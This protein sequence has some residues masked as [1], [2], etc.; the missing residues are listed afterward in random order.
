MIEPWIIS[1]LDLLQTHP[2]I[3]LRDPQRMIQKGAYAVDG[4][5]EQ[6]GFTVLF[7]T[8]NLG[9]RDLYERL[10]DDPNT[11]V[12][13][14]DRSRGD[15]TRPLFY[16]D[17]AASAGRTQQITLTL[18]D[19]LVE[20]TGDAKWP[21]LVD[22]RGLSRLV[23]ATLPETIEAHRALRRVDTSRFADSDLYK[24]V[25]GAALR[26]DPFKKLSTSEIRRLC[27]EQ[28]QA[29]E[30]LKGVLPADVLD[31]LQRTIQAA[32]RP[33]CWLLDRDPVLVLRAFTLAT[34]MHEHGLEYQILLSNL[35]PALHEYR[36]ID[37]AFLDQALQD[38][39][40]ADPD[41]VIADVQDAEAFLLEEPSRLAFLLHDRL[42]IEEPRQAIETLKRERLSPLMRGLALV[43]L[44][45]DLIIDK[46]VKTHRKVI[47]LL[48]K[49]TAEATLPALRR[50]G[51]SWET[52]ERT[53]RRA[54]EVFELT[55]R[56]A[57]HGKKLAVAPA[58]DLTLEEFDR[59]WNQE[60]LNRLDYYVSDL[61]RM[62]RIGAM[63]PA[64]ISAFWP[65]LAARWD[66][67]RNRLKEVADAVVEVQALINRRFQDL[68][69]LHFATWIR[70]ADA[71]VVFTHQFL[72]RMLQAHWDPLSKRKAVILVFD[73]LRTDAW[74]ELLRPVLEERY[75]VV[76]SRPGSALLPTET[77]LSRKAIAAGCLP[78]EFKS[79]SELDLLQTWLKS[80]MGLSLRFQ[81]V[82]D[83]D[84]VA[85]GMSVRY[86]SDRLDY[87]VFNFTDKNLHGNDQDLA[88][89]YNTTVREIIRQDV[90]SVLRELPGDALVFVTSDHGFA[91]VAKQP[92]AI[93]ER[94]VN[95]PDDVK[96][97][98]ARTRGKLESPDAEQTVDFDARLLGIPLSTSRVSNVHFNTVLF[99]RPTVTFKRPTGGFHP[100]R[101]T[102]GGLSLAECF[103][104]MVVMSRRQEQRL[105]LEI[106]SV[107]QVG[108]VSEGEL[109]SLEIVIKPLQVGPTDLAIT[110]SFSRED[111]PTRREVF[112][113]QAATYT[114]TWTPKLGDVS[115]EDRE[116]N[117]V[118]LPVTVILSYVRGQQTTRLSK[119]IDV[120]IKLD[121]TRLRRRLDSKLDLLMG[122][123]PSELR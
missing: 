83:D 27:I 56:L 45:A 61:E 34:L 14:V 53:Y 87:V 12:L 76:E 96:Y 59:L 63:L 54:L 5:A 28:H 58:Q 84:T 81:V 89:I 70:Q 60:G 31:T 79:A 90:R 43:A 6:N 10:R 7:C 50:P 113:G 121:P 88:F 98:N 52:L 16:P 104:P 69:R 9:L 78:A 99:P 95:S 32:P 91:P 46:D 20:V 97:R 49:Q 75:Q 111:I 73:G 2:L 8:G 110:L 105:A 92:L 65:E 3:I 17:L 51:E 93:P 64:P 107:Q 77:Q 57:T 114:V 42:R 13:L 18:R 112:T 4:W 38:Q 21:P 1:K 101:Y 11:H 74:D 94:L 29:I 66:A 85:S 33:F 117:A 67:A 82:K 55:A 102:H 120:R 35:D 71:P 30:D 108:S 39:L 26:I 72:P 115:D 48:D 19:Y 116:R 40:A 41:R 122:K 62:V 37:A 25:L 23:L 103:V 44:L 100:D 109:L 123:V 106:A 68:Y 47:A 118:V 80:A 15:A 36:D 24:I 86:V 22:E 119:T